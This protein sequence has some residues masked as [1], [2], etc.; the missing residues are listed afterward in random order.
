MHF[1]FSRVYFRR[2]IC[3][4][5]RTAAEFICFPVTHNIH[6]S[7]NKNIKISYCLLNRSCNHLIFRN[8]SNNSIEKIKDWTSVSTKQYH[9]NERNLFIFLSKKLITL[10]CD[11]SCIIF[12]YLTQFLTLLLHFLHFDFHSCV[13]LS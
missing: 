11:H 5:F 12:F 9:L 8:F 2:M 4:S 3:F 13:F 6:W 1:E 7:K 10:L